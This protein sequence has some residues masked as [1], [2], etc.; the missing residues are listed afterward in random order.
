LRFVIEERGMTDDE[1]AIRQVI[2]TWMKASRD[3]D[4][5][6]VLSL[7][8]EDAVFMVPGRP[9]FGREAFAQASNAM[10]GVRLEGTSEVVELQVQGD[11]AFSRN[12]ID[13]VM[14]PPSGKPL[15]RAGYTLTLYRKK[16]DGRWRL[17]RDAN[18]LTVQS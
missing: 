17:M 1:R 11:W 7:M 4:T 5:A 12:H 18:L 6:T 3:G 13:L 10:A 15:R 9:P 14:T 16:A 8:T 2:E